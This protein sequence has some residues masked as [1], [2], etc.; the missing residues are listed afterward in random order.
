M[1][2]LVRLAGLALQRV[3]LGLLGGCDG[4][5]GGKGCG[6]KGDDGHPGHIVLLGF[7]R[8][9]AGSCTKDAAPLRTPTRHMI[10]FR[11]ARETL[12][13]A[14]AGLNLISSASC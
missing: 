8:R 10:F 5:K 6:Q 4:C 13:Q 7:C 2:R 1:A 12:N 9:P 14:L 11:D 3:F